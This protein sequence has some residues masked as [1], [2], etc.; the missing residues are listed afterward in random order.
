MPPIDASTGQPLQWVLA[1]AATSAPGR[2]V[3][4]IETLVDQGLRPLLDRLQNTRHGKVALHISGALVDHLEGSARDLIG[5][6]QRLVADHRLELLAGPYYG[7]PLSAVPERDAVAQLQLS[8]D[9]IR[10]RIDA[11]VRGGWLPTGA[12]DSVIPRILA[13]AGLNFTLLDQRLLPWADRGWVAAERDGFTVGVLPMVQS[14]S[15]VVLSGHQRDLAQALRHLA[16]KQSLACTVV[17]LM[18]PGHQGSPVGWLGPAF[19]LMRDEQSWLKAS[20]PSAALEGGAGGSRAAPASGL[21]PEIGS[22]ALVT[23][24]QVQSQGVPWSQFLVRSDDGNRLHKR[25]LRVSRQIER[26]RAAS[27]Q[28]RRRHLAERQVQEASLD[29]YQ[30]QNAEYFMPSPRGQLERAEVR[31]AAWVALARAEDRARAEVPPPPTPH[32]TD[33]DGDGIPE[34]YISTSALDAVIRPGR[35]GALTELNLPGVGNLLNTLQRQRPVWADDVQREERLPQLVSGPTLSHVEADEVEIEESTGVFHRPMEDE[36]A[37]LFR[38]ETQKTDL[39]DRQDE[40]VFIPPELDDLLVDDS[41]PRLAFQERFPGPELSTDNIARAQA[42]EL[43]DFVDGGYRLVRS[44]LMDDGDQVVVLTRDGQVHTHEGP[45]MVRITKRYSFPRDATAIGVHYDVINRYSDPIHTWFGIEF[46]LNLDGGRGEGRGLQ[47]RV[48]DPEA[49][50]GI[51]TRPVAMEAAARID[52]VVEVGWCL[53]D[54]GRRVWLATPQAAQLFVV[55]IDAVRW[56][57]D[58]FE[59]APQG[60]CL[61]FVW[62]LELWG[63]ERKRFDMSLRVEAQAAS[64]LG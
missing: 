39:V 8:V 41:A 25:M 22:E 35:G 30:G 24:A 37:Q 5:Q 27:S 45:K 50:D 21:P 4:E 47:V 43:G 63:D 49:P 23:D 48:T 18:R 3:G 10:T 52:N 2:P 54:H 61:L 9:W 28:A 19:D 29:L 7:A 12:W 32:T 16:V 64:R 31:H 46:N 34:V 56:A 55:P 6:L 51:I 40:T 42:P 11:S 53:D 38:L 58:G 26:M 44:D 60:H 59:R 36:D 14:L 20:L 62:D 1:V 17:P 33:A 57:L 15:E 13:R